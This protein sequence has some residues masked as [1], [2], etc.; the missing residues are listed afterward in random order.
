LSQ[1]ISQV[2]RNRDFV[3]IDANALEQVPEHDT[4]GGGVLNN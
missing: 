3:D 4:E 2:P 1:S